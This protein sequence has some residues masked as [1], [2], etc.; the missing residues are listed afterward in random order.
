MNARKATSENSYAHTPP[1][2]KKVRVQASTATFAIGSVKNPRR[3]ISSFAVQ[4]SAGLT[5]ASVAEIR[6]AGN[7]SRTQFGT[8]GSGGG[9]LETRLQAALVDCNL[10]F[11][12]N[13]MEPRSTFIE[14]FQHISPHSTRV[15][16]LA[17]CFSRFPDLHILVLLDSNNH[18]A[19]LHDEKKDDIDIVP[20]QD[21]PVLWKDVQVHHRTVP[22]SL[23]LFLVDQ[24]AKRFNTIAGD[25]RNA[26]EL[27]TIPVFKRCC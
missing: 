23:L 18:F 2:R 24:T 6:I 14:R 13:R 19:F 9:G 15:S 10:N 25:I 12:Q 17:R 1:A 11:N 8:A 4:D 16:F 20:V 3:T 7:P 5:P 21:V 22:S 27:R 26:Q